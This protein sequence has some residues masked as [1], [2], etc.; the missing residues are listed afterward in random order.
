MRRILTVALDAAVTLGILLA[1][2]VLASVLAFAALGL[3]PA[4]CAAVGAG[5]FLAVVGAACVSR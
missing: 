1:G 4:A 2:C 3:D 5:G